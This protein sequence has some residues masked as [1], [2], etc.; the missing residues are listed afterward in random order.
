MDTKLTNR[1]VY[2][3]ILLS[4]VQSVGLALRKEYNTKNIILYYRSDCII[5]Y[6]IA[7]I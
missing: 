6:Y 7:I 4:S 5:I 3:K 2:R 1:Y